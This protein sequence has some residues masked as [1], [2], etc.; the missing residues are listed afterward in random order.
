M[1]TSKSGVNI[2]QANTKP[3]QKYMSVL[4]FAIG[5]IFRPIGLE[6]PYIIYIYMQSVHQPYLPPPHHP[7]F[8]TTK[9][10]SDAFMNKLRQ[11]LFN[12][13]DVLL[14]YFEVSS[15]ESQIGVVWPLFEILNSLLIFCCFYKITIKS[16]IQDSPTKRLMSSVNTNQGV[17]SI[18]IHIQDLTLKLLSNL[19]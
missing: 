9:I 3:L 8:W 13:S 17:L 11:I 1:I 12:R 4:N 6:R 14:T 16:V 18:T 5:K 7:H 2:F 15:L 10:V 19:N